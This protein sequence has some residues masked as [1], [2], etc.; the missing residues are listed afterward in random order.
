MEELVNPNNGVVCR[1]FA[2]ESLTEGLQEV[3]HKEYDTST[4][5]N[6]IVQRFDSNV[7]ANHYI[8]L[9]NKILHP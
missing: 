9:Y 7:I 8:E 3:I 4:L 6:D 2:T 1:D 5:H